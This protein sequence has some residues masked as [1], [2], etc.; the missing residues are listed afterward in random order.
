MQTCNPRI[1]PRLVLSMRDRHP[2]C[3]VYTPEEC[4]WG[5]EVK[6]GRNLVNPSHL[7]IRKTYYP[8]KYTIFKKTILDIVWVLLNYSK[9]KEW[10]GEA[11]LTLRVE[12]WGSEITIMEYIWIS[13]QMFAII[14]VMLLCLCICISEKKWGGGW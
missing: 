2:I 6:E 7:N 11:Q 3:V 8:T 4:K 5:D 1:K 9:A 10:V 14:I 13:P 12:G